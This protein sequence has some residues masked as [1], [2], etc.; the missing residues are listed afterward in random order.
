MGEVCADIITPNKEGFSR[1]IFVIQAH[2]SHISPHTH[3][4]SLACLSFKRERKAIG[5]LA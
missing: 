3:T 2:E 4:Y 1:E 5:H